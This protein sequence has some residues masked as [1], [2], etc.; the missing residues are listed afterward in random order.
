MVA[1]KSVASKAPA[2]APKT[3]KAAGDKKNVQKNVKKPTLPI[4]S[5]SYV[6]STLK[7]VSPNVQCKQ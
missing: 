6:K 2:K 4:S 5:V 7:L 3:V 1:Q